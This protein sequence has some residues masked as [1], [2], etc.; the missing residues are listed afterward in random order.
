MRALPIVVLPAFLL[1]VAAC[2][3]STPAATTPGAG[4]KTPA[5]S[6]SIGGG[7]TSP[8]SDKVTW[9]KDASPKNCHTGAKGKDVGAEVLAM[10]SA[11]T[12]GMKQLGQ[13]HLGE[14]GGAT[15]GTPGGMIKTIPFKAQ[16][17]KCYRFFGIAEATVTDFDI[18]I[19]DSASKSAGE[20][21]TDSNDAIVLEDGNICFKVDDD[22]SINVAVGNGS[23][24]WAVAVFSD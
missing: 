21:L 14:G 12:S 9:K 11:C 20:D 10:A 2:G 15:A 3:G 22:V 1:S 18:A 5:K 19:I 6:T 8:D 7:P 24:K 13:T 23:G 17:N 16:A 4:D